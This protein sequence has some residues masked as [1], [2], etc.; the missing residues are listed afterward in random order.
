MQESIFSKN[1]LDDLTADV[2]VAHSNIINRVSLN[3]YQILK[4]CLCINR[5]VFTMK[6]R[7][8]KEDLT[9]RG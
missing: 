5:F 7:S 6:E 2:I 8:W 1:L 9:G 3:S 4:L